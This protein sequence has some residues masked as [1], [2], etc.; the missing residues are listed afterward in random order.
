MG[1]LNHIVINLFILFFTVI[2][3]CLENPEKVPVQVN[4]SNTAKILS[5]IES[6]GD[7]PNSLSAPAMISA[8]DL[9]NNLNSYVILD[10]RSNTDY[11][12]GHI[13]NSIN[14]GNKQLY[15]YIDS[16][17]IIDI[18][19]QI[20]IVCNDG[21]ASAYY[22]CL[23]RL[24]GFIDIYSLKYGLASWNVFFATNWLNAIETVGNYSN[25]TNVNFPKPGASAL[26]E[27]SI[28][29]SM[30]SNKDIAVYRVKEIL[31]E[32]FSQSQFARNL[33]L[34]NQDSSF[35]ICY[36]IERLYIEP[37]LQFGAGHAYGVLWFNSEP[38]HEFRSTKNLQNIPNKFP[39][40]IYC[41][42]GQLSACIAAYL[43]V[44]G[45]DAKFL[46]FGANQLFYYRMLNDPILSSYSFDLS[47]IMNYPYITGN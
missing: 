16:V 21:Q 45:Y 10:I 26:P 47:D 28:P 17:K 42:D 27:L 12:N 43:R 7:Y 5:Y 3:G 20:V 4:L 13:T 23:L 8:N 35:N 6:I 24:A 29:G 11:A 31:K 14:I 41:T 40:L 32:G 25:Y 19:R 39:I 2:T 22:T 33:N 15:H 37:P 44:L 30:T 18:N 46:L 38:F 9:F 34:E 1:K 36:G